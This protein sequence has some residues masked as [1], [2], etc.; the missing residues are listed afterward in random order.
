MNYMVLAILIQ[1]TY[2][3]VHAELDTESLK[4]H[5]DYET[6]MI[7]EIDAEGPEDCNNSSALVFSGTNSEKNYTCTLVY[8]NADFSSLKT[9]CWCKTQMPRFVY[10]DNYTVYLLTGKISSHLKN[11]IPCNNIKPRAPHILNVKHGENG[12]FRV[13]WEN[14]YSN[15]SFLYDS[16]NFQLSYGIKEKGDEVATVLNVSDFFYEIL[17][18]SLNPGRDYVV[19]VR[20]YSSNYQ[21]QFSDWSQEL[22]WHNSMTVP[23]ILKVGI[24]VLCVLLIITIVSSYRFYTRL[25]KSWWDKIP[26]PGN[27]RINHVYSA[28]TKLVLS[29]LY[30]K[31]IINNL[32]LDMQTSGIIEK[33]WPP[34]LDGDATLEKFNSVISKTV[35]E[36][37]KVVVTES[38]YHGCSSSYEADYPDTITTY[39]LTKERDTANSEIITQ[40]QNALRA[41]FCQHDIFHAHHP[42]AFIPTSVLHNSMD[43]CNAYSG[44]DNC[45]LMKNRNPGC[46]ELNVLPFT[47]D[48]QAHHFR[49]SVSSTGSSESGYKSI[50]YSWVSL[51]EYPV[52]KMESS[53]ELVLS[54]RPPMTAQPEVWC[55]P[56]Y[57]GL[58]LNTCLNN[59][60]KCPLSSMNTDSLKGPFL[61]TPVQTISEYQSYDGN[62]TLLTNGTTVFLSSRSL[63][64]GAGNLLSSPG[65]L[66]LADGYQ[67]LN[68]TRT[69]RN[70][71][72]TNFS[73]ATTEQ[74]PTDIDWQLETKLICN[75]NPAYADLKISAC[76]TSSCVEGYQPFQTMVEKISIDKP[77]VQH[78]KHVVS[79]KSLQDLQLS[80]FSGLNLTE[81]PKDG[82]TICVSD[83]HGL[84]NPHTRINPDKDSHPGSVI[85]IPEMTIMPIDSTYKKL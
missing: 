39:S 18:S 47:T 49:S 44:S 77:P 81:I 60:E 84:Q 55:D 46:G 48:G 54:E 75:V 80:C 12:N 67:S 3:L 2:S 24:P 37:Q 56:S 71:D 66:Q 34:S 72:V 52:F 40:T 35:E 17:K 20:S 36:D 25:K 22:E 1:L 10:N 23:D 13:T 41:L 30:C 76:S 4:C 16:L 43:V 82:P 33:L 32:T 26:N 73:V 68:D 19:K 14:N 29:P 8:K 57:Q 78:L 15:E 74:T 70:S 42:K 21:T 62:G 11:I 31:P 38:P 83:Y 61:P 69:K 27:S 63:L 28:N 64:C 85:A 51:K 58:C 59:N 79:S 65:A 50:P 9:H 45:A 5:N 53:K 7:C 6:T